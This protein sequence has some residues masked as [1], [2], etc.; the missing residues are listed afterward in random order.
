MYIIAPSVR[1]DGR[2]PFTNWA[3]NKHGLI[4]LAN[5]ADLKVLDASVAGIPNPDVGAEWDTVWDDAVL[6]ALKGENSH[7]LPTQKL[8]FERRVSSH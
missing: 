5:W 3:F 7:G 1:Y 6:I 4:A 2:Y 8:H